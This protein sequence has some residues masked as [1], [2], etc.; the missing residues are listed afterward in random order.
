MLLLRR[1]PALEGGL[2]MTRYHDRLEAG[3][4]TATPTMPKTTRRRRKVETPE[5]EPQPEPPPDDDGD[6][7]DE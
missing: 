7:E 1:V 6:D 4:F 3:E 2:P 5:P